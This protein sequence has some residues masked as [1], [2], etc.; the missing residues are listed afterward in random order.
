MQA[1][2][3]ALVGAAGAF[4][5]ST[6]GQTTPLITFRNIGKSFGKLEAVRNVNLDVRE[7]EIMTLLG[8]SGCGKST[9]LNMTAG[10][11][12]PSTGELFYDEAPVTGLNDQ[13]GYMTQSDHLLDWRTARANIQLPLE[14]RGVGRSEAKE[15][16]AELVELVGLRGFENAYPKQLSGGMRKRVALARLLAYNPETLLMDE[17]FAALDAQ[18]RMKMQIQLR[19]LCRRMNKTVLFVTHDVDEAVA[20]SDRCAIFSKRPG[21]IE[22][23]ISIELDPNRE[24][25]GLR[26]DPAYQRITSEL[27]DHILRNEGLN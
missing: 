16:V 26:K 17:P 14:I 2:S 15:T 8:P 23:C 10:L 13:V 20:L 25:H 7:G 12:A 27:F 6:A 3:D 5:A 18:L 11:F 21:T 24:I 1:S 22:D 4:H 19:A 9:L